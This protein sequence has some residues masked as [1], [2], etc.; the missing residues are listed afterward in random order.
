MSNTMFERKLFVL[1]ATK[2]TYHDYE[3]PTTLYF[4][5]EQEVERYEQATGEI[6][7]QFAVEITREFAHIINIAYKEGFRDG[8]EAAAL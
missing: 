3:K 4:D 5:P 2:S 8:K 7:C 6:V 1:K